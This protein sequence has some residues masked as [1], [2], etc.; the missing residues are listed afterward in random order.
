[1]RL[2]GDL[3]SGLAQCD[4]RVIVTAHAAFGYLALRYDLTQ[5]AISG[6]SPESEPDPDRLAELADVV[7]A[8]GI[9]TIFYESLVPP[10]L[11]ETL[12][13]E[14]DVTTAVLNPI[15][16]LT[17]DEEADGATY[18]TLMRENLAS[19]RASLDCR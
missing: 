2:D 5:R 14:A 15:E 7:E 18:E 4:R 9:T 6:L 1:M 19:L 17:D 13:R 11:A 3:A 8:D 16:G 12:A 10:D